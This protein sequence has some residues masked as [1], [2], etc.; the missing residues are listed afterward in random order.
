VLLAAVPIVSAEQWTFSKYVAHFQKQYDV[1][2]LPYRQGIFEKILA[3][4]ERH[5]ALNESYEL[6]I[7]H[8][9]DLTSDEFSAYLGRK[10]SKSLVASPKPMLQTGDFPPSVDWRDKKVVS[11]IKN[12]GSCGSC[13][14]FASTEQV[15]S[16]VALS[17]AALPILAPQHLVSCDTNPQHCG[18][19]GGCGG[20][21]PELAFDFVQKNGLAL[22]KDYPYMGRDS[23]CNQTAAAHPAASLTGYVRLMQN[24]YKSVMQA[25]STIG[26]LAVNVWAIPFQSYRSGVYNGCNYKASMDVDHVMQLVGYGTD[27]GK[28]YWIVRNS[29]GPSWGEN[30]YIRLAR[31]PQSLQTCGLDMTPADGTGCDGEPA[32][33]GVCGQ[34]GILYDVSYPTGVKAK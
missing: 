31:E 1:S 30:G 17:G 9:S 18:G 16:Y 10:G 27:A 26:P 22:E 14:A 19:T 28:D 8:F 7:N 24:D 23:P 32:V 6:G 4:V 3:Q 13:W 33:V 25:L 5:N 12:Q 11:P 15:E 2:E 29:W 21:I 34:C 20:S